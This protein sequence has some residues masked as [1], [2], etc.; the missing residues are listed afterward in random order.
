[1]AMTKRERFMNFLAGRPVDRVPV[2]FFHHF[3]SP[4]EWFTGLENPEAFEKNVMGH[5][6]AL[7]KFDPDVIKVM[8]DSLMVMP[9]DTSF[10]E[11]SKDLLNIKPPVKGSPYFEKTR[12]LTQR[13]LEFYKGSDAP[14]YVTGF[15]PATV[16]KGSLEGLFGTEHRLLKFLEEDPDSVVAALDIIGESI[17]QLDEMLIKE[18]GA[19]GVYFSVNNQ[20]NYF[21][22]ELFLKYVAPADKKVMA[23]ANG[24]SKINL[25]HICGYHGKANDLTL[26][27]DYEAAAYNI[28]VYAE[29]VPLSEGKKL[30]G[31][32]PVFG[33]FSQD[34]VIYTGTKEE[35]KEAT[36]KILDECGQ[37]GVMIGDDCTVPND[38][39]DSRFNWV[40]EACEEYAAKH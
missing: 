12:E 11:T 25:L 22:K 4:T 17:M 30:F 8:N 5:K 29:G 15:S 38:I 23:H 27:Q 19:D 20:S 7:E 16:L 36:W 24:L 10:V 1:M 40:I 31:G 13:V 3:C 37:L 33:G 2:A 9:L 28:A 26:F 14:K 39:D 35:V 6:Y 18:C 34:G 21:P 32:K